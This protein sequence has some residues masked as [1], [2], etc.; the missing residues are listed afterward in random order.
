MENNANKKRHF[1]FSLFS[2]LASGLMVVIGFAIE[3]G[4]KYGNVAYG[5]IP[6]LLIVYVL[7]LFGAFITADSLR[8][9]LN[10]T[11]F[12]F[13]GHV[14]LLYLLGAAGT[15]VLSHNLI[16][17]LSLLVIGAGSALGLTARHFHVIYP[18]IVL[19]DTITLLNNYRL[20]LALSLSSLMIYT[21]ILLKIG[22]RLGES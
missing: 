21:L 6:P 7:Y 13:V 14:F 4:R 9:K 2:L 10:R 1:V 18:L 17:S 16:F 22:S 3:F 11:P 8:G 19:I 20:L 12:S 5:F 15:W